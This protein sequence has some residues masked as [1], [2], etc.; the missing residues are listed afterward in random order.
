MRVVAGEL[1]VDHPTGVLGQQVARAGEVG[2]VSAFLARVDGVAVQALNLALLDLTVPVGALYQPQ[3]NAFAKLT[4]EQRQ[5]DQHRQAAFGIS[6]DDQAKLTPAGDS[7]VAQELFVQF[8]RQLEA[9]GLL[10]IDGDPDIALTRQ[11]GQFAHT[12]E[13]LGEHALALG[14]FVARMQC[15]QL[16]RHRRTR[17]LADLRL[18]ADGLHGL[19]VVGHV[20][21]GV[22]G[23]Q[24]RLTE[25]VEGISVAL[26][27]LGTAVL[28]RFGDG[29]AK[30]ELL[31]HQLHRLVHCAADHWLAGA[32]EQAADDVLRPAIGGFRIDHLAG[33][34][35]PPGGE[36]DQ[37]VVALAEVAFPFGGVELVADQRVSRGGIR[38]PQQRFGQAHQH[39]PFLGVQAVLAQQRIEGIDGILTPAHRLDQAARALA[40]GGNARLAGIGKLQQFGEILRL[41]NG[42]IGADGGKEFRGFLVGEGAFQ[43]VTGLEHAP[44]LL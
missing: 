43:H 5:P 25:H 29:A 33:H 36:V 26:L 32:L 11:H 31:A 21:G 44:L 39:Q 22:F 12:G 19:T 20:L 41:V 40:N 34:H 18:G 10:G 1:R 24:C 2:G 8:Q 28:Q 38:H 15:R 27:A 7:R 6:L 16:D 4:T 42:V 23:S 9:V 3:R 17:A 35:Q 14:D 13:Q 30:H 37:H